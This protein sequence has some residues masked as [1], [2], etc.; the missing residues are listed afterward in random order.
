MVIHRSRVRRDEED[1][2][3]LAACAL[4]HFENTKER[5]R[6]RRDVCKMNCLF[7][8]HADVGV[9]HY[10]SVSSPPRT[11]E[12]NQTET[13]SH[14]L[15]LKHPVHSKTCSREWQTVAR[16]THIH[17]LRT[18]AKRNRSPKHF[19][20]LGLLANTCSGLIRNCLCVV[21]ECG[22][23]VSST[24]ASHESLGAEFFEC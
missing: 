17:Q 13:F 5:C 23:S 15:V 21:Q 19:K 12:F 20:Q 4:G 22:Y 10:G 3:M 8:G 6:K 9:V 11:N 16:R 24:T 2:L 14:I 7:D 18:R 1:I